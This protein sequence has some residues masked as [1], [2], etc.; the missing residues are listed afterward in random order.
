M[1]DSKHSDFQKAITI[2]I[3]GNSNFRELIGQL[4]VELYHEFECLGYIDASEATQIQ[5]PRSLYPKQRH[6]RTEPIGLISIAIF[7]GTTIGA[8]ALEKIL[9]EILEQ[10]IKPAFQKLKNNFMRKD[11]KDESTD[12]EITFKFGIWYAADQVYINVVARLATPEDF[13]SLEFLLPQVEQAAY[14][15]LLDKR[16]ESRV[17]TYYIVDGKIPEQPMLS[18]SIPID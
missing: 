2:N 13:D 3:S 14:D 5:I 17:L 18:E 11:A 9:D 6:F 16:V 8:W 4:E 15:W 7:L 12:L 1:L 10:K